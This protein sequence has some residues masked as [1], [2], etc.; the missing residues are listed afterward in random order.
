MTT[1]TAVSITT[2]Y[3]DVRRTVELTLIQHGVE[4]TDDDIARV[5]PE[6][7]VRNILIRSEYRRRTDA[8]EKAEAVVEDLSERFS[9]SR[10]AVWQIVCHS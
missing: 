7:Q 3:R 1:S 9:V 10:S 2:L 4:P 8:G 5:L 6:H